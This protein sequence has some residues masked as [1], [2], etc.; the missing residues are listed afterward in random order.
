[1]GRKW[2]SSALVGSGLLLASLTFSPA[3]LAAQE[4]L[5][6]ASA[7]AAEMAQPGYGFHQTKWQ[8]WSPNRKETASAKPPSP[9]PVE[10]KPLTRTMSGEVDAVQ[11]KT[12]TRA[13]STPADPVQPKPF[14]R[15]LSTPV[16]NFPTKTSAPILTTPVASILPPAKAF[17]ES[18]ST[19][20]P[21][22][23]ASLMPITPPVRRRAIEP[24]PAIQKVSYEESA[25]V[26]KTAVSPSPTKLV[27]S[28][29]EP[30]KL[31]WI[32]S[33]PAPLPQVSASKMPEKPKTVPAAEV[34][35][36]TIEWVPVGPAT[37]P[38]KPRS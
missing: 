1:M 35:P 26:N 20:K 25:L 28:E 5:G 19:R 37:S 33:P 10:P 31:T 14:T 21:Q 2:N 12:I 9:D 29:G 17:P 38:Y 15:A 23:V 6:P 32:A 4:K 34:A 18:T 16:T 8:A 3:R 36:V 30:Q 7:K 22:T 27:V 13:L 24:Q 11:P